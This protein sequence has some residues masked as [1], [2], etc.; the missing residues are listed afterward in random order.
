ML[1]MAHLLESSL[2]LPVP[3]REVFDF[4]SRAENLGRITPPELHFR[5]LTPTPVEM[6][7]GTLL[8]YQIRLWRVP[9]D[10]RTRIDVW[11]PPVRFVD[12]QISGPYREWVHTHTFQECPGGTEIFD[13]VLYQLPFW[14]AGELAL[15][16]VRLQLK[17]I[18]R[19][20]REAVRALLLQRSEAEAPAV[21]SL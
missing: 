3:I 19:F 12:R 13:R 4:F 2:T 17:R 18:F 15:P 8:D 5:I 14:P 21:R 1:R 9:L 6:R 7:E 16:I 11:E 20:R 10:W